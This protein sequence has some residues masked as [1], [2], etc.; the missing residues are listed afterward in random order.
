MA[1]HS[2]KKI[3]LVKFQRL[4]SSKGT[5]A[6]LY[7]SMAF[8]ENL[9][10]FWFCVAK[11]LISENDKISTG[12]KRGLKAAEKLACRKPGQSSNRDPCGL[13]TVDLLNTLHLSL[14]EGQM[15]RA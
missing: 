8:C 4:Y 7:N 3:F 5:G 9:Y 15:Q 2:V 1:H 14:G 10:C 13:T 11:G 6:F 12:A